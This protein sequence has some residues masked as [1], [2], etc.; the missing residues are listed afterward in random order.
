MQNAA[1][2]PP[3]SFTEHHHHRLPSAHTQIQI[4]IHT[5]PIRPGSVMGSVRQ[6]CLQILQKDSKEEC[7]RT[8]GNTSSYDMHPAPGLY[9]SST[10]ALENAPSSVG[11][12]GADRTI[13]PSGGQ[14]RRYFS[15][16]TRNSGLLYMTSYGLWSQ[17]A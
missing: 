17:T 10:L 6:S 11:Q 5:I 1:K 15:L 14:G 9:C 13:V 12:D 8:Q 2:A 7:V 16:R 3:S 4:I